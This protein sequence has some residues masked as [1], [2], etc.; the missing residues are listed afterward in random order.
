MDISGVVTDPARPDHTQAI[1]ALLSSCVVLKQR[2]E[3]NP[4]PLCTEFVVSKDYLEQIK[5]ECEKLNQNH[6]GAR[7]I[8]PIMF[9]ENF[10]TPTVKHHCCKTSV[11]SSVRACSNK[12]KPD[13]KIWARY[14]KWFKEVFKPEYVRHWN[15]QDRVVNAQDWLSK[16]PLQYRAEMLKSV[17]NDHKRF[18]LN[19]RFKAFPKIE[20]QITEIPVD[21]KE[22]EKNEVK[23]RQ[24]CGPITQKKWVNAFIDKLE[25]VAHLHMRGYCGRKNWVE[26]CETIEKMDSLRNLLW[27]DADGSGFDMTQLMANNKLMDELI[28]E[29]A[30]SFRTQLPDELSVSDI[31][32]ALKES[33]MLKVQMDNRNIL[34]TVEGRASGDGWT[35]F[36][37]TMLMLSYY[38]FLAHEAQVDLELLVKGDDTVIGAEPRDVRKVDQIHRQLFTYTKVEQEYGLG[39]ISAPLKFGSILDCSFL[40]SHFFYDSRE[41]LRM[42]RIPSRVLQTISWTTKITDSMA[43][44]KK[45]SEVARQLVYSKGKCLEAWASDLPIWGALARKMVE[46]GKFGRHSEYCQY[47]DAIR[48]WRPASDYQAYMVYLERYGVTERSV[49]QIERKIN[50]I[51]SLSGLVE[52]P[53]LATLY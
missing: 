29:C 47:A 34:Y 3:I 39:Q 2:L 20:M 10:K 48:V 25:E 45:V 37:N 43:K 42:T 51:T 30:T 33:W 4:G 50:S 28:L 18:N 22:S 7:Q 6:I 40:S 49:R 15:K 31:E 36:S 27:A 44:S 16:Y 13:E 41:R 1:K 46:L 32:E 38:R 5:A 53:E 8:F 35:T 17:D 14:E 52:I 26:I 11:A 12:V 21:L 23:E 9:S 19:S 24:I